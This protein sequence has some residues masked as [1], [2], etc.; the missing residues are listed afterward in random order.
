MSVRQA[1]GLKP[2]EDARRCM[3]LERLI[4]RTSEWV[5]AVVRRVGRRSL[6]K[7]AW[8]C[9]CERERWK[10]W[11]GKTDYVVGAELDLESI[12]SQ[13]GWHCHDAGVVH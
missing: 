10:M 8:P 6:V 5:V 7:R 13:G 1:V 12:F 3:S 9:E 11:R 2:G 4:M